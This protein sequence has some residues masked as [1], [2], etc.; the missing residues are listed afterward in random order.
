MT[1]LLK[2]KPNDTFPTTVK[3]LPKNYNF[4]INKTLRTIKKLGAKKIALQFPD[5]LLSYAPII[6]D[7][8]TSYFDTDITILNDVVYGACCVDNSFKCDLLIHYGHSCLISVAEM[9]TRVLYVFID[10]R[11]DIE[12]L[13]ELIKRNFS[14]QKVALI[15]TIQFNGAV[16]RIG[17]IL[18]KDNTIDLQIPQA[19]PLSKG[20]VLGCTSP[21]IKAEIC[22]YIGDG[23]FH[24]EA[25]MI[26]NRNVKF[27][28]YCPFNR[29]LS[30]EKYDNSQ[31]LRDR[32][33]EIVKF[34]AAE[35]IGIVL[36]N[37]GM[38]GN[39]K[40]FNNLCKRLQAKGK[41]LYKIESDEINADILNTF[42]YVDAFVQV[43]CP[44]L[45][46]DWGK[47][48]NKPLLNP[49]E[50]LSEIKNDYEMDYYGNEG[51][52]EWQNY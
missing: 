52:N 24:L 15:G 36:S 5:G 46:I 43:G 12:H 4:E 35:N 2:E 32:K 50:M 27:Y 49:Y 16:N 8:I 22:V 38:Q 40:I 42:S 33:E 41:K 6:I 3:G 1:I 47:N 23:R 48:Y 10:I 37:L 7:T 17:N 39:M 44:R 20:E 18:K 19:K 31:M 26:K 13:I 30:R 14:Q 51:G 28:K 21:L 34:W 45:S 25:A 29:K 9:K 11:I